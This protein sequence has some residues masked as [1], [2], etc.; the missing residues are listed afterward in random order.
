[1]GMTEEIKAYILASSLGN[2]PWI[3]PVANSTTG[4]I[5]ENFRPGS[6]D[7]VCCLYQLPGGRP[8]LGLGGTVMWYNP[9]LQVVTRGAVNDHVTAKLDAAQIRD[10]LIGVVNTSLS[11]TRY[12][13]IV[14]DGEPVAL[15]L[16]ANN[17][18]L[19]STEYS[20]MKYASE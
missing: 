7:R 10:L 6:P 20:V 4:N 13:R 12:L 5:F 19:Y 11:G 1:M 16:D 2:N 9:R 14:P 15:A 17:R 3:D 8:Q 18:P